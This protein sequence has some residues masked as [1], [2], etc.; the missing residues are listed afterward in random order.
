MYVIAVVCFW[1]W[2]EIF[3]GLL[4]LKMF[5][6]VHMLLLGLTQSFPCINSKLQANIA[7][8]SITDMRLHRFIQSCIS[9]MALFTPWRDEILNN[10]N[11]VCFSNLITMLRH[12]I[13]N[14]LCMCVCILSHLLLALLC[15]L[16]SIIAMVVGT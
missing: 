15:H 9:V 3:I 14:I 10:S 16:P 8:S 2:T 13:S 6:D 7:P 1:S 5:V 11:F 4:L 12:N